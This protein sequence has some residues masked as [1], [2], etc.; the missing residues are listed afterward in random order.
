MKAPGGG[1]DEVGDAQAEIHEIEDATELLALLVD[2]LS[3]Q[4]EQHL[5][6]VDF[7]RADLVTCAAERRGVGQRLRV[8]HL[9]ELWGENCAD[10]PG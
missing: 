1:E 3:A 2:N 7:D 8:L 9:H 10:G 5:G 6:N 4:F